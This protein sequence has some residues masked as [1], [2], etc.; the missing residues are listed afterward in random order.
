MNDKQQT[1]DFDAFK[2]TSDPIEASFESAKEMLDS[3]RSINGAA[4]ADMV[5]LANT[6]SQIMHTVASMSQLLP[7]DVPK[8]LIDKI[9]TSVADHMAHIMQLSCRYSMRDL[10]DDSGDLHDA[11]KKTVKDILEWSDKIMEIKMSGAKKFMEGFERRGGG[12]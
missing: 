9:F 12:H 7:T 6:S 3:I 8:F 4:Y 10:F 11:G 2:T 1:T 5:D